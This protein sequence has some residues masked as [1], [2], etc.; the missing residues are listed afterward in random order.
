MTNAVIVF[1]KAPV[2]G[3]VKTRLCPPLALAEAA[4]LAR[5]FLIDSVARACALPQV[6]V[7]L[8]F[9]PA[10]SE[11]L[12]RELLPFPL[13]Y[14]L[15]RGASLGEREMHAFADVFAAGFS[16]AVLIG[17]DIPTLPSAHLQEAFAHLA[18]PENDVV[19]GPSL[20][21]GY[22]LIG[23]RGLHPALFENIHWST[24]SVLEETLAQARRAGLRVA[25]V[26]TWY[27]VDEQA[28]LQK[29]IDEL[30]PSDNANRA[31]RTRAV[32]ARLG[33]LSVRAS[34]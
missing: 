6:Q 25:H 18:E 7:C 34:T 14:F 16:G 31:P 4:D 23:A 10:E 30:T 2:V 9:T 19:I 15:Q 29:L 22:Y 27:D 3:Q 12:F 1:A 13:R 32:L 17:S 33:F 28:D 8:A 21:G 11:S 24:A 20:D 5:C 26:P